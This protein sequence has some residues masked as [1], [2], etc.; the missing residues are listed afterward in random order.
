MSQYTTIETKGW[1]RE[2]AF[3]FFRKFDDPFFN[4]SANVD[5]TE[6]H[7][8]CKRSGLPFSLCTLFLTAQTANEIEV[9][10][11]R[12]VNG[13]VRLYDLVHC[14]ATVLHDDE[15]FSFCYYAMKPDLR[16]FVETAVQLTAAHKQNPNFDPGDNIHD[17][18]HCSVVPWISFTAIKHARRF[19]REDSIPK[20][21]FGKKIEQSGRWL[22][23][24]SLEAHHGLMDGLH[25]GRFFEGLQKK[26]DEVG[27]GGN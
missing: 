5:V 9:F 16:Q 19:G 2:A 13:E 8:F 4:I 3:R 7:H 21:V 12:L 22:M 23:P 11:L 26:L 25:A 17:V 1:K 20:L 15:T 27:V 24:I 10:R 6:L 18:L 14:G